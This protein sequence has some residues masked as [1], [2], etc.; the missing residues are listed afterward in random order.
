LNLRSGA[1]IVISKGRAAM[2]LN[3]PTTLCLI[4][5]VGAAA[6]LLLRTSGKLARQRQRSAT[7]EWEGRNRGGPRPDRD[8]GQGILPGDLA[9]WEVEMHETARQL[10]AQLDAKLSLLQA[11]IADASLASERLEDALNRAR[12]VLPPGS[13]AESLRPIAGYGR[14]LSELDSE[15]AEPV[16]SADDNPPADRTRRRDEIYQLAD[17]GF[18]A[19]EIAR[20]VGSPVGEVELIL[21]LRQPSSP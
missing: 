8:L 5:L 11:L 17:Y 15:V 7:T 1:R 21:S 6:F 19:T 2:N 4:L 16:L 20:R 14:D 9:Q 10:S 13:Q 12:P 18:A 3:D